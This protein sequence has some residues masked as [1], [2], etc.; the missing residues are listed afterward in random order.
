MKHNT[1]LDESERGWTCE[2]SEDKMVWRCGKNG[3]RPD[4]QR[5]NTTTQ[6]EKADQHLETWKDGG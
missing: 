6:E 5:N 2:G 1:E 4:A 3:G